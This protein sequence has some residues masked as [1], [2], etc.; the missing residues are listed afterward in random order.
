[1][2]L[3]DGIPLEEHLNNLK[4]KNEK[5]AEERIWKIL[6]QVSKSEWLLNIITTC[7]VI[8]MDD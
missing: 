2:E 6:M 5:F 8:I 4:D 1:M 7:L 3:I